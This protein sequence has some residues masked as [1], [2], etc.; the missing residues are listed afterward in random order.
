V[1]VIG[2]ARS[3]HGVGQSVRAFV[4]ALDAA[5]IT[6][7]VIDFNEGNLSRT[8]DHTLEPRFVSEPAH[9][10]NVFH[11]NA[12]QM[13]VAELHLPAHVF[14]R[15]NIGYW[16]WELPEMHDEHLS[17][18]RRVNEVWVPS[19]F[20]QDAVSKKSPVPVLRM[21]HAVQFNASAEG[22]RQRFG[23]PHDR[24][25]FLTMYDF[26]SIQER[27]NPSAAL[28]AF[29]RAFNGGETKATLV[30]KTQNADFH[31][32][33]L[34]MLR[35]KLSGRTDVV[36]INETL[37]RQDVY[38]L[39]ASCDALVSLHR[40]EGFGL[41]LAEAMFLGKP[42]VATNWSGNTDFMRPDNSY[43]VNFR[44]VPIER[45]FGVY[46][47]GQIWADPDVE[48]AASLMRQVVNDERLRERVSM[49]A[50]QT[51]RDE[52]SPESVGRRIRARLEYVQSVLASR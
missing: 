8:Q 37:S 48:H 15:F 41:S 42:V 35:E 33:D 52:F 36:W 22:A 44:L 14:E 20:V 12:D 47:A 29:N 23:L 13:V 50:M 5:D 6:S 43:P 31:P 38:D 1:N 30:I 40:S 28:E 16:A 2:Y 11:I 10:I 4:A 39:L 17:G 49:A 21:P 19:A 25:L 32:Q 18:F 45:D 34:A 9:G 27:K 3:E 26:S 7:S 51:I 24:F 46:R